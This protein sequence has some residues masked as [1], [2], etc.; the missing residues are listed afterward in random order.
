MS[1]KN[2]LGVLQNGTRPASA[3]LR[4]INDL[5][6]N[7]H[8]SNGVINAIIDFVLTVNNNVLSR[9]YSEKIAASLAREG[10]TTAV[11]AMNYLRRIYRPKDKEAPIASPKKVETTGGEETE[12]K[13]KTPSSKDE[14]SWEEM[15]DDLDGGGSDGKA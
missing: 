5:S 12:N 7:F 13:Q 2:Y 14:P 4:L 1:P 8:L 3:D 15:I 6:S 10:L 9:A 11:D